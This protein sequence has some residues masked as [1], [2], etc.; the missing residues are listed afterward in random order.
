MQN[1]ICLLS[2]ILLLPGCWTEFVSP[3]IR[4]HVIPHFLLM[5]YRFLMQAEAHLSL[6]VYSIIVGCESMFLLVYLCIDDHVDSLF[7]RPLPL[8]LVELALN[9]ILQLVFRLF[10]FRGSL[11]LH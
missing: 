3:E 6:K 10:L 8:H 1:L 4:W 9:D 11:R 2:R 5:Q 7:L